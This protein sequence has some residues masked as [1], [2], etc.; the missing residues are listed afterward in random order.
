[1]ADRRSKSGGRP[2]MTKHDLWRLNDLGLNSNNNNNI[3]S[4]A[5]CPDFLDTP[6]GHNYGARGLEGVGI[7]GQAEKAMSD[8]DG[9]PDPS[10][11]AEDAELS[12]RLRELDKR[13]GDRRIDL[14]GDVGEEK[15]RSPGAAMA[16]R[17]GADFV[18]GVVV[19]AALGWGF[20]KLFGTSPW[21]LVAFLLL[22][23]AAG[24]LSVMRSAGLVRP[25]PGDPGGG[26]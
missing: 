14:G 2:G 12:R 11:N 4:L 23:F 25:R 22:G 20:D 24:I 16:L 10:S 13:I 5:I 17:L 15:P 9:V 3:N 7:P 6:W 18:A 21:G 26:R 8:R 1:M 19:G